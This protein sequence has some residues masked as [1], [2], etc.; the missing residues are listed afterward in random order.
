[1]KIEIGFFSI[2]T[3]IFVVAKL[4]KIIDW[5]WWIVFLPAIIGLSLG[6]IVLLFVAIIF[7]FALI[8]VS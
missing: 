1:M 3:L 6:L 7:I 8:K 4:L 5:S 2:L